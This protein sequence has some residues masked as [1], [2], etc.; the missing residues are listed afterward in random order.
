VARLRRSHPRFD[1]ETLR[2]QYRCRSFAGVQNERDVKRGTYFHYATAF[3]GS[4][5]GTLADVVHAALEQ[6]R[7]DL[8]ALRLYDLDRGERAWTLAAGLPVYVSLFGRDTLTAAWQSSLVTTD[9]LRGIRQPS[10]WSLT[11]SF[12]ERLKDALV[13]FIK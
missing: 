2:P 8:I 10:P 7:H 5:T 1:G 13:S 11:A 4:G 6:A 12:A 3:S 9:V